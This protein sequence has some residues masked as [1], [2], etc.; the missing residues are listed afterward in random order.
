MLPHFG[1]HRRCEKDRASGSE[2]GVGQQVVGEPVRGLGEQ[3]C[4]RRRDDDE[5][6]DASDQDV[7]D[8][9]CVGPDIGR[10]SVMRQRRPGCLADELQGSLR[11]HH[12]YLMAGLDKPAEQ[13]GSLVSG[14]TT[15]NTQDDP[16]GCRLVRVGLGHSAGLG[17]GL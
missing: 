10:N 1:M 5:I 15:S 11:R 17:L 16:L 13:V 14:D 3:V 8:L 7:R 9:V 2:Q 12:R 6:G 4:S